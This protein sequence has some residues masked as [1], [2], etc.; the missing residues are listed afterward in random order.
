MAPAPAGDYRIAWITLAAPQSCS[1]CGVGLIPTGRRALRFEKGPGV[2]RLYGRW[3][4][5]LSCLARCAEL[6]AEEEDDRSPGRGEPYRTLA[7]WA[8]SEERAHRAAGQL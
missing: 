7:W 4:H 5:G 8:Q 1:G 2:Q 3:F 6:S